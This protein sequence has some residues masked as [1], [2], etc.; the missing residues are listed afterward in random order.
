MIYPEY[1][2]K[3]KYKNET[4]HQITYFYPNGTS[5]LNGIVVRATNRSLICTDTLTGILGEYLLSAYRIVISC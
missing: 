1:L 4:N 3:I 5:F 2:E